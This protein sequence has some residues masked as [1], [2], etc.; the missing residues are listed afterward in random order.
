M[1]IHSVS[2]VLQDCLVDMDVLETAALGASVS[3][4]HAKDVGK[5]LNRILGLQVEKQNLVIN[6]KQIELFKDE[7]M[8]LKFVL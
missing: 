8:F 1:F 5:F 4:R 6:F 3:E 7:H 2:R